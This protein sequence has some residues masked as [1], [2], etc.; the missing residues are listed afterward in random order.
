VP[1]A[2]APESAPAAGAVDAF[3]GGADVGGTTATESA[4]AGGTAPAPA[5]QPQ[6]SQEMR[7]SVTG[8]ME[9]VPGAWQERQDARASGAAPSGDAPR[10]ITQ[11]K[12]ESVT[13]LTTSP[14]PAGAAGAREED[15]GV[16]A[17]QAHSPEDQPVAKDEAANEKSRTTEAAGRA[18]PAPVDPSDLS[19]AAP[20]PA[21]PST[22]APS[23]DRVV[24][25]FASPPR[26]T[27]RLMPPAAPVQTTPF[28]GEAPALQAR[29]EDA[30]AKHDAARRARA[31]AG[32]DI[33]AATWEGLVP[34]LATSPAQVEARWRAADAR[35]RAWRA[36]P[37]P[38]REAAAGAA[39][40]AFAAVAPAD[41]R[42]RTLMSPSL[43]W[44]QSKQTYR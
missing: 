35:Q 26:H 44:G 30:L 41:P 33:A 7:R 3:R 11:L 23:A 31:G 15:A 14:T 37:T 18:R 27:K 22:L 10:T 25:G 17:Q 28:D 12:R 13:P 9:P 21:A 2:A 1:D 24:E 5:V 43:P 40:R 39:A 38:A 32:W 20:A 8:E 36:E 34:A 4:P 16:R 42:V 19:A 29:I 6:R